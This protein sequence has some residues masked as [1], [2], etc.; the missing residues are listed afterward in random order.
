MVSD[1]LKKI[2]FKKLYKDLSKVEIIPY[3]GSV[4]FI[5]RENKYWYFELGDDGF[6]WWRYSFFVDFFELFSLDI[7]DFEPIIGEWVEN[8]LNCKVSKANLFESVSSFSLD[9]I[10]NCKVL[11]VH[12]GVSVQPY[13]VGEVLN[14]KVYTTQCGN[15]GCPDLVNEVLNSKVLTVGESDFFKE[16]EVDEVLNSKST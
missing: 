9:G 15:F 14:C 8:I 3:E 7:N 1:R 10:L 4:W 5:D 2:I 11:T 13:N 6:L 12:G 16:S